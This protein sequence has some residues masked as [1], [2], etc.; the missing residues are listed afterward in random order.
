M[1][2]H[3]AWIPAKQLQRS[4]SEPVPV[5]IDSGIGYLKDGACA[6]TAMG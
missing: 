6:G 1:L 4:Q 5:V 2:L 3:Q